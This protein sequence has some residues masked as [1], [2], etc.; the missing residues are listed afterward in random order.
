MQWQ[1][2]AASSLALAAMLWAA[3][4]QAQTRI[5]TVDEL[6]VKG[7]PVYDVKAYGARGNGVTDD[8]AAI[9][10]AL[11]A[12]PAAGGVV[13]LPPGV[14]GVSAPLNIN[15]FTILRGS[16]HQGS[17]IRALAGFAGAAMVQNAIQDGSQQFIGI[18]SLLVNGNK[19]V[20]TVAIGI[21]IKGGGQ[22]T[23][24]RDVVVYE[25]SGNGL[26]LDGGTSGSAG[27]LVENVQVASSNDHNIVL[28]G[29]LYATMLQHVTSEFQAAGK[30][31]IYLDG[32]PAGIGQRSI[33]LTDIHV[34]FQGAE[35]FGVLISSF[36][37]VLIDGLVYIGDIVTG[38]LVKIVGN[39]ADTNQIVLRNL[40]VSDGRLANIVND[41]PRLA[42]PSTTTSYVR[43]YSTGGAF[44]SPMYVA[45]GGDLQLRIGDTARTLYFDFSRVAGTGALSIQG[46]QTGAN[47]I[48]LAPTSGNVGIGT[49]TPTLFKLQTAGHVG[50]DAHATYDLA[51]TATRWR[52][53]FFSFLSADELHAK[54]FTADI[55]QA[56]VGG[57]IIAKSVVVVAAAFTLPVQGAST[58]FIVEDIANMAAVDVF[59]AGDFVRFRQFTRGVNTL[60]V[61][62]AWGAISATAH[63]HNGDGTQTWTFVRSATPNEGAATGTITRGQLV[64][65]YGVSGDGLIEATVLDSSGQT[66]A[67][68]TRYLTWTTHPKT[69]QVVQ[70]QIGQLNGTY[71]YGA[72]TFGLAAG[73]YVVGGS[74]LAV[75]PTNGVRA[76][77]RIAGPSNVT[78]FQLAADGSGTLANGN[79]AWTTAGVTTIAGWVIAAADLKDVAGTV[80][81]SSAVT[82]GDDIRFWAG[83]ATP[84]SAPFRVT[85]AGALVASS[86]TVSGTVNATAGYFGDGATRVAIEAA[87]INVGNTGSIRGGQTAYN[88]G[89]GFW[90]GYDGGTYKLSLG[91]DDADRMT[92][93][94]TNLSVV[95]QYFNVSTSGVRIAYTTE[96]TEART[97]GFT[98]SYA[99]IGFYDPGGGVPSVLQVGTEGSVYF[100]GRDPSTGNQTWLWSLVDQT[101]S[102]RKADLIP[103]QSTGYYIGGPD[104]PIERVYATT[105]YGGGVAGTSDGATNAA[106]TS[107]NVE[108]GIVTSIGTTG[109]VSTTTDCSGGCTF[110]YGLLTSQSSLGNPLILG[111]LL[112]LERENAALWAELAALRALLEGRR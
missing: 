6:R 102:G 83:H 49:T 3:A 111:R 112:Q 101:G 23:Y 36:Q 89:T 31:A 43:E 29:A 25:A 105:F 56:L 71:D 85:E 55:E 14:Y 8:T 76:M 86:A 18:E 15:A 104:W 94:G 28:T 109:G 78:R 22:P 81:L 99:G 93:D 100:K 47:N 11:D 39:A 84:A 98:D 106:V 90:L 95:S 46:N 37:N 67:P 107:I 5:F 103:G 35:S 53:G 80:G 21:K 13:F 45:T 91:H 4:A 68:Y 2:W 20:A 60:D 12:V 27:F 64:I 40:C 79:I 57:Q 108:G 69:G 38:D 44:Y 92:W 1:R 32:A 10:A 66:N 19:S 17:E 70:A 73:P 63:T 88:T 26:V 74:F 34:E 61:A 30:A 42:I 16:G 62:D 33:Y 110:T 65:D 82:G 72:S 77:T 9:N 58:T 96:V 54:A 51:A 41:T 97:Y 24:V 87:G 59:V 48:L 52:G 7:S 75:D 50:P